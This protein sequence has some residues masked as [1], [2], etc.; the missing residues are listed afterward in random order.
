M[1]RLELVWRAA[2]NVLTDKQLEAFTLRHGSDYSFQRIGDELGISRQAAR[3]R[4][5]GSERKVKRALDDLL[6]KVV[7]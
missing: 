5:L 2:H 4:V 7:A 1:N 6:W 3:E